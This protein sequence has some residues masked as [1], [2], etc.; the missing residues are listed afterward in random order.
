MLQPSKHI[1]IAR[2]IQ[3]EVAD[4]NVEIK[5]T[6][7]LDRRDYHISSKKILD[8]LGYQPVSSIR[9]EVAQL[10]KALDSRMF[11]DVDAPTHYNMKFMK[12]G[13]NPSSYKYLSR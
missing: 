2:L 11:A 5:V 10:R 3:S 7:T 1:E 6:D 13:R 9:A 4:L 8:V 12:L